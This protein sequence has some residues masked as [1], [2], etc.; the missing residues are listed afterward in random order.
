M[1]IYLIEDHE[2]VATVIA[3]NQERALAY[4]FDSYVYQTD[5]YNIIKLGV[6]TKDVFDSTKPGVVCLQ[7]KTPT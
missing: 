6:V 5:G 3:P 4:A 2:M 1:N 7:D